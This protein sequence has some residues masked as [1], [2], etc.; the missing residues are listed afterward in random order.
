MIS[1]SDQ[2]HRGAT[3]GDT[4]TRPVCGLTADLPTPL[5]Y[6]VVWSLDLGGVFG[7][8]VSDLL[9]YQEHLLFSHVC[10]V[11]AHLETVEVAVDEVFQ[12]DHLAVWRSDEHP[13]ETRFV[14]V[15]SLPVI[16]QLHE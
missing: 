5:T 2:R 12:V 15:V 10:V 11:R 9:A 3:L 8:E 6:E 13:L 1:S 14:T 7:P 4:R 16:R